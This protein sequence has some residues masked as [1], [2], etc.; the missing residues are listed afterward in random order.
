MKYM[1]MK[2]FDFFFRSLLLLLLSLFSFLF[3]GSYICKGMITRQLGGKVHTIH[4]YLPYS[5]ISCRVFLP[6]S[7]LR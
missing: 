2:E 1:M 7:L 6:L 4:T 3:L 5:S